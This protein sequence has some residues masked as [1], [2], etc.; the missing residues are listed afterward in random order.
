MYILIT[1][2][3]NEEN[4][5]SQTLN[6]LLHQDVKPK[7][8]VIV[9]DNNIDKTSKVLGKYFH[10]FSWMSSRKYFI[11][12]NMSD[13]KILIFS[14]IFFDYWI[15]KCFYYGKNSRIYEHSILYIFITG[16]L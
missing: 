11:K 3:K 1:P 15:L 8:W 5:L 13:I 4:N 2:V 12:R 6:S 10:K 9:D 7:L 14:Q 16:L